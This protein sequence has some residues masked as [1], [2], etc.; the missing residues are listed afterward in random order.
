M[1][2]A[3]ILGPERHA[4]SAG[5]KKAVIACCSLLAIDLWR[6][7]TRQITPEDVGFQTV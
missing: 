4:G 6:I 1:K 2:F 7:E 3:H 5:R